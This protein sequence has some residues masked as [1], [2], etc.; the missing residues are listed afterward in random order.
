M[1]IPV[2]I[3]QEQVSEL[4]LSR[5]GLYTVLELEI[6]GSADRLVRLW[7]HGSGKSAYLGV[8]QPWSGGL[9]LRR[10]LT[11]RELAAFPDP[12]EFVSDREQSGEAEYETNESKHKEVDINK[13]EETDKQSPPENESSTEEKTDRGLHND[14]SAPEEEPEPSRTQTDTRACPWPAEPPEEGLL[15]Y[16]REDGSLTAFDGV[17]SLLAIP[18]ELRKRTPQMTERMIEGKKYLVFRY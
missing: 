1:T 16:R 14:D 5:D 9:Y 18:A 17:S 10:R 13:T 6:P 15:W 2:Y 8:M 4:R 7:V 3:N 12:I 11:R